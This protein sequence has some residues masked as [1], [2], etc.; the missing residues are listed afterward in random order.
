MA[1]TPSQNST[2]KVKGTKTFSSLSRP[3]QSHT[4][5]GTYTGASPM[6]RWISQSPKDEPWNNIGGVRTVAGSH[7]EKNHDTTSSRGGVAGSHSG[8]AKQ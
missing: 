3:W 7:S 2:S 4:I 5:S 8:N 1:P 6:D